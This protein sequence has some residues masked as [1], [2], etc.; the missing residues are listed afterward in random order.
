[1]PPKKILRI[2]QKR[3]D[4]AEGFDVQLIVTNEWDESFNG[5]IVLS[6]TSNVP[7]EAWMLSFDTNFEIADLWGGALVESS[8][9][10]SAN[11]LFGLE[12]FNG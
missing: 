8:L 12:R 4:I 9:I 11:F 10:E 3:V 7:L 2:S 5:D 6:N 1:L